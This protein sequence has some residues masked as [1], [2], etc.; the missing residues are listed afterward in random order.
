MY[1]FAGT[2]KFIDKVRRKANDIL[3][4]M[5]CKEKVINILNNFKIKAKKNRY[6][7]RPIIELLEMKQRRLRGQTK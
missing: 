2:L 5:N 3:Y 7:S 6:V 1:E 4:I